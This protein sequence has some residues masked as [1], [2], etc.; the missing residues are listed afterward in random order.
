[1]KT[2]FIAKA[3]SVILACAILALLLVPRGFASGGINGDSDSSA[4]SACAD[5]AGAFPTIVY[6]RLYIGQNTS[7]SGFEIHLAGANGDCSEL[8]YSSNAVENG[9]SFGYQQDP[10]DWVLISR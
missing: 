1:L 2:S 6:T 8:L 5:K 10:D 7:I 4:Q 9:I 3:A